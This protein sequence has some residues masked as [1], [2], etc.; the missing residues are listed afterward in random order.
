MRV[1]ASLYRN[2]V[3]LTII[4]VIA[5]IATVKILNHT[6]QLHY[7]REFNE[8]IMPLINEKNNEKIFYATNAETDPKQYKNVLDISGG[9]LRNT[10]FV[11]YLLRLNNYYLDKNIDMLRMFNVFGGVSAGAIITGA[12]AYREHVLK[13]CVKNDKSSL[14]EC[15]KMFKYTDVQITKCIELILHDSR[16]LN[17]GTLILQWIFYEFISLKDKLFN[18]SVFDRITTLNGFLHPQ[19]SSSDK[20]AYLKRYFD[21]DIKSILKTRKF[22]TCAIKIGN[23]KNVASYGTANEPNYGTPNQIIVFTNSEREFNNPNLVTYDHVTTNVA[24]IIHIS[25]NTIGIYPVCPQYPFAWD[26]TVYMNNISTLIIPLFLNHSVNPNLNYFGLSNIKNLTYEKTEGLV[27]WIKNV[28][29]LV[30]IQTKYDMQIMKFLQK[31][32]YHNVIIDKGDN[33]AFDLSINGM[34][35]DIRNGSG[36]SINDSVKFIRDEMMSSANHNFFDNM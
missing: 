6:K 29:S 20:R 8:L 3:V 14:I 10:R 9:G 13:N 32:K 4:V 12:I 16:E 34:L 21:F 11:V 7:E 5:V 33:N 19:F 2:A 1:V 28:N 22:I 24:D 31:N 17:Y 36:V 25:T 23:E 15:M 26:A 27:W 30:R 35:N 18:V